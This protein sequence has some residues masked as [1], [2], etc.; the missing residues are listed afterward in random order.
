MAFGTAIRRSMMARLVGMAAAVAA[1]LPTTRAAVP[2]AVRRAARQ[3]AV[4]PT[5]TRVVPA[6]AQAGTQEV[7]VT[8][9]ALPEGAMPVATQAALSAAGAL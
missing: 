8:A 1:M 7:V 6:G 3:A 2:Q 9:A 4:S 5:A